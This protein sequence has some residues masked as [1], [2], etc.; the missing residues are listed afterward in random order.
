M[1]LKGI[2]AAPTLILVIM[3][4]LL[5]FRLIDPAQLG[6]YEN[7]YLSV[8]IL[9]LVILALPAVFFCRLRSGSG[10]APG[11]GY[12][13]R[14]RLR[15]FG[16]E[17]IYLLI[18]ALLVLLF[19]SALI[20]LLMYY[21]GSETA[22]F[23]TYSPVPNMSSALEVTGMVSGLYAILA[24]AV[25]PGIT[26]EFLFRSIIAAEYE[27]NGV[28]C[29]VILNSLLF[30]LL[31]FDWQQIPVY[32]FS[33]VVLSMTL[34]ASRSVLACMA[35][36]VLNNIFHLFLEN[37]LWN[38]V[39]R[40][41][42]AVVFLFIVATLFLISVILFFGAAAR[43]YTRM[44]VLAYPSPHA[45]GFRKKRREQ[46]LSPGAPLL[47]ALLAPPFLVALIFF[48]AVTVFT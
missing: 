5:A 15:F 24:F 16:T 17:H 22:A 2:F 21:T 40:P 43:L 30:S 25:L 26:E 3:V 46:K 37:Y 19:G 23:D 36:H 44:G 48:L 11:G 33:G 38:I 20:K 6:M 29:A 34:Y 14:L 8:I 45:D 9:Q 4:F 35:V 18:V 31:H 13:S 10:D 32:F 1:K 28:F 42:N 41:R 27:E 12:L 39:S 47:E 7:P